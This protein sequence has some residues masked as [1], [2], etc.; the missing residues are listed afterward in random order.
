MMAKVKLN[1][2]VKVDGKF[3]K[4]GEEVEVTA[5][6][7]KTLEKAGVIGEA[8][9]DNSPNSDKEIQSLVAKVA[10][11]EKENEALKA[12]LEKATKK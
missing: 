12:D 4:A 9:K 7:K 11:L 10:N 5:E 8:K 3:V 6:V 1:K 2:S